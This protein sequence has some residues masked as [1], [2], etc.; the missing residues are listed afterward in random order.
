MSSP[1]AGQRGRP[2]ALP[3]FVKLLSASVDLQLY[4]GRAEICH[5]MV[6]MEPEPGM[7]PSLVQQAR[8]DAALWFDLPGAGHPS[9]ESGGG[10]SWSLVA[11]NQLPLAIR[12]TAHSTQE[13]A[14]RDALAFLRSS[15]E[16]RMLEVTSRTTKQRGAW[17]VRDQTVWL[18]GGRLWRRPDASLRNALERLL[19]HQGAPLSAPTP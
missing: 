6:E 10:W 8:R 1:Q 3:P 19:R 18:V 11:P 9:S 7:C 13:A 14:K 4:L 15:E 17:L 5:Q 16:V 2:R 12:V